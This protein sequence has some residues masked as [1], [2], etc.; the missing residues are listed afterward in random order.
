MVAFYVTEK[1]GELWS[2][3]FPNSMT[4]VSISLKCQKVGTFMVAKVPT[5]IQTKENR[6]PRMFSIMHINKQ[7]KVVSSKQWQ[8]E[9][10]HNNLHE[11]YFRNWWA[12]CHLLLIR[13]YLA[14]HLYHWWVLRHSW[15]LQ[16]I[17]QSNFVLAFQIKKI[18]HHVKEVSVP[19]RRLLDN[20][21]Q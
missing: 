16:P 9:T 20:V 4:F 17:W 5:C 18:T 21:L 11:S 6:R 15:L 13:Y 7:Q 8:K 3:W 14:A 10:K 1:C 12:I 19:I 2:F